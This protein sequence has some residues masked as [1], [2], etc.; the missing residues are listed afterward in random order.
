VTQGE[1]KTKRESWTV[2]DGEAEAARAKRAFE[3]G[4]REVARGA[5]R[6]SV[7]VIWG[8]ALLGGTVALLALVRIVRRRPAQLVIR[9][10]VEPGRSALP[11]WSAAPVLGSTLAR[12]ALRRL[13]AGAPESGR[14]ASGAA[15]VRTLARMGHNN[16]SAV[17]GQ[18][19]PLV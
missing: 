11:I 5:R 12:L 15:F 10:S 6:V 2:T 8:V 18:H 17:H 9:V 3:G 7:P 19:D 13:A 16:G 4:L 14:F 1:N